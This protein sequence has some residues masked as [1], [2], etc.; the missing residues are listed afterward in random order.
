MPDDTTKVSP[1]RLPKYPI[2]L[3]QRTPIPCQRDH[4]TLETLFDRGE[5]R[6]LNWEID[7]VGK[8]PM[9]VLNG[10][11][12]CSRVE[13]C[14]SHTAGSLPDWSFPENPLT[15]SARGSFMQ[16]LDRSRIVRD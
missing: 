8:A 15:R 5:D 13:F 10:D 2:Q 16:Q 4:D 9:T 6:A 11:D 3:P 14:E 7:P 1:E 12:I